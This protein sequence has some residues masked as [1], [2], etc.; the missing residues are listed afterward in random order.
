MDNGLKFKCPICTNITEL[1]IEYY[2]RRMYNLNNPGSKV[3]GY[4]MP[5][6]EHGT[7]EYTASMDYMVRTL[8]KLNY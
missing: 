2:Q 7:I 3:E 6:L 5:E 1:P 4:D 8:K